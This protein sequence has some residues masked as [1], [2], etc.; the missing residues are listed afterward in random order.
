VPTL[1]FL[2]RKTETE[3]FDEIKSFLASKGVVIERWE[4]AQKLSDN[5]SQ[6]TILAAYA[7]EL[8]PFMQKGGYTTAD[9]VNIHGNVPN[10]DVIRA[11][12]L[13]EHT[14]SEDEVRFFVDGE[15]G[16]YFHFEDPEEVV[17]VVCRAGD[18]ISVPKGYKHWFD[19]APKNFVKAIRIFIDQSGW[20]PNYTGS[21]TEKRYVK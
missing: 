7:H 2:D 8:K 15:G 5:D 11:K 9:V 10:L 20:V 19:F 6:E 4:A 13:Q 21:E 12:F 3:N 1:K 18:F 14:H 17:C 16:F